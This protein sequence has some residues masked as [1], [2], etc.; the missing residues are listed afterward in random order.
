[1]SGLR[2]VLAAFGWG[3]FVMGAFAAILSAPAPTVFLFFI[4][5]LFLQ[6]AAN[7]CRP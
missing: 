3:A 6:V 4:V 5:A 1:M 7:G 2:I